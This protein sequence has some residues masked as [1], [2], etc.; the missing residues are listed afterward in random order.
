MIA[1]RVLRR[2]RRVPLAVHLFITPHY[3]CIYACFLSR[4]IRHGAM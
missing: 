4:D 1:V 2:S 3:A